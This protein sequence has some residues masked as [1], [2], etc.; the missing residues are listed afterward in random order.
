MNSGTQLGAAPAPGNSY[1]WTSVPEGFTSTEANPLV[2]PRVTT[3]YILVETNASTGCSNSHPVVVTVN[4]LPKAIAGKNRSICLNGNTRIGGNPVPG[5]SYFWTSVPE[6][7][8]SSESNP[9]VAPQITTTYILTETITATGCSKSGSVMVT[10]NPLPDAIAGENRAICLNSNTQ[11]GAPPFAGRTYRWSSVPVGFTSTLANPIVSPTVTTTYTLVETIPATGCTN[12]NSVTVT[13]NPLPAANA[14]NNKEICIHSSTQLGANPVTGSTYHWTSVPEGFTSTL[15]NPM[16]TPLVTTLYTLVET[17][18]ATGCSNDNSVVITVYP[19]LLAGSISASQTICAGTIPEQLMGV[20]PENGT[21]ATYQWQKSENNTLFTD[22]PG[23]IGLDYQPDVLMN[24][25]Y[26]RQLQNATGTCGGPLSTNVLMIAVNPM[27]A[28]AGNIS[29]PDEV[30]QGQTG[31]IYSVPEIEM[32]T[33]YSWE[34]PSGAYIASGDNTHSIVVN[35]SETALSGEISVYGTN[36]CGNGI[37]SPALNITVIPLV[38]IQLNVGDVVVADGDVNCYNAQQTITV[39]GDGT[40]FTIQEGGSATMIAGQNIRFLSGTTV[41]NG[42]YLHG[43]IT[44]DGSYCGSLPPSMVNTLPE[45]LANV[46]Y[47]GRESAFFKVYPNPTTGKFVL[48]L[49]EEHLP[50]KIFVQ[51]YSMTGTMILK[52]EKTG[53]RKYEIL[54]HDKQ[55]GIYVISVTN[56]ER[57]GTAKII[58]E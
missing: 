22:I 2:S 48:E 9:W 18:T 36:D 7:F 25:T 29:G 53:N 31:V 14:G 19:V 10:V 52:E 21:S 26:F 47:L 1:S 43:Y 23:A 35:F 32:A 17:T 28:V 37:P 56:G 40:F 41:E 6:G 49:L 16:V 55:P 8:T 27:P 54:I 12:S 50:S 11:L 44:T 57:S 3:T 45:V 33:G 51:I 38:P 46:D 24:T 15:A 39:A 4:P 58:K 42:G 30:Q 5:N 34:L 20:A 13:V